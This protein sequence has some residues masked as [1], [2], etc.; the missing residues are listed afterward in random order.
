MRYYP[1]LK[2]YKARNVTLDPM[3]MR[4]YSYQWWRFVDR[5]DGLIIFN[6]YRYSNSTSGHQ[7]K[8]SRQLRELGVTSRISI[9]APEGL[10]NLGSAIAYYTARIN[11]LK[12]AIARKGSRKAT[13]AERLRRIN[14][15]RFKIQQVRYLLKRKEL[16]A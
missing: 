6:W 14:H 2:L 8:V 4:A 13:N 11:S 9:E 3:S 12:I 5:I 10:Q 1:R 7:A 15:Y 16:A